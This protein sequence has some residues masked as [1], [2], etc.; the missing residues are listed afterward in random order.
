M[1]GDVLTFLLTDVEGSTRQWEEF[2]DAMGE[3]IAVHDQLIGTTVGAHHGRVIKE[4]GEGDSIF[5][6]FVHPADAIAAAATLQ[7]AIA[8]AAWPSSISMSVRIGI[9]SGP[10]TVRDGD[11]Y[12]PTVNLCAR[13]RASASGGQIVVSE[14][15]A[16]PTS[17]RLP[18]G[19]ALRDLGEHR[20]R[21]IASRVRVFQ[22]EARGLPSTFPPLRTLD[23]PTNLPSALTD[24]VGRDEEL[25]RGQ[26]LLADA[27]LVTIVGPG[28]SGKTRFALQLA[29]TALASFPDG[30]FFAP[31]APLRDHALVTSTIAQVLGVREVSGRSLMDRL[32]EAL[33]A[34]VT[35][36]VLD[37]FEHVID[38]A[39]VVAQLLASCPRMRVLATSTRLLRVRGER[40]LPLGP[41]PLEGTTD[42]PAPAVALFL[43]RAAAADPAFEESPEQLAAAIA[44]CRRLDGIP[45]AIELAAAR[46][47]LHRP[48]ELLVRLDRGLASL[49]GGARD[50]PERQRTMRSSIAWTADLLSEGA[51]VLLRRV[52]A[53]AGGFTLGSAEAVCALDGLDVEGAM[54]ELVESSLIQRE[55]SDRFAMLRL[56]REFALERLAEAGEATAVRRR[57]AAR[58]VALAERT[59]P[60]VT[61]H[62]RREAL[63]TFAADREDMRAALD[64]AAA[65]DHEL[66]A[67]LAVA[68]TWVWY[69]E[70]AFSEGIDRLE[71]ALHHQQRPTLAR[72]YV[73]FGLGMLRYYRGDT[74][75]ASALSQAR[76]LFRELGNARG[77]V[78]SAV[79]LAN[80][81]VDRSD[82]RARD[83]AAEAREAAAQVD[84]PWVVALASVYSG[85]ATALVSPDLGAARR[86]LEE[87]VA[88]AGPDGDP[89]LLSAALYYLGV[90]D[91]RRGALDAARI[92]IERSLAMFKD[93]GD[94][95]RVGVAL[96]ALARLAE[97]QGEPE[98][99]AA[100]R[101]EAE[102]VRRELR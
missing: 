33:A 30:V 3:A 77:S 26:G 73:L 78:L 14:A 10:A 93:I 62:Q 9:H 85:I 27:R 59:A 71:A 80:S 87:G 75:A 6:V 47:R 1:S 64:T 24:L 60:R 100:L 53:F 4:R 98:R 40:E 36:L 91:M 83:I 16:S 42:E 94:R 56:I 18:E 68:L 69:Q 34:K 13:L 46:V 29:A 54:G 38:A 76:E 99:A 63:A 20:L 15:A 48:T 90:I 67:R 17:G 21:D 5:A 22:V 58:Y 96:D 84:D 2:P 79:W 51:R 66:E 23:T 57:H 102:V 25:A 32:L 31:L 74:A 81:A 45:L 70:G 55:T 37:N 8:A 95:W 97:R 86:S 28:G 12:G 7:Q 101:A 35:L 72:A 65:E 50:L 89:W 92:A 43:E 61:S 52:G 82:P 44:I 41:L 49:A 88:L 39:P 11:Y 19:I